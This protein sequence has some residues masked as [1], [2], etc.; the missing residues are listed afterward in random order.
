MTDQLARPTGFDF[1]DLDRTWLR[2]K[3]GV[4]WR[5]PDPDVLP[6][7]LADM[8]FPVAPPIRDALAEVMQRGDLGYPAW[9]TWSGLNPL[10]EPFGTRMS[11]FYGWQPQPEWLFNFSDI[12][13]ILQIILH[14]TTSPGDA[15]VLQ[16]PNYPPFLKTIQLMRRR[17]V[18]NPIEWSGNGWEFDPERLEQAVRTSAC[19][20]MMVVNPH[21]P[22]GRVFTRVELESLADIAVRNDMLVLADE[23]LADLAYAPRHHIPLASIGPEIAERTVTLSSI[24]KAFNVSGL[25][26]AVAHVG[27][28]HLRDELASY[29]PDFF[30]PVNVLGVEATKAAWQFGDAWL[31][32]LV[33]HLRCNRDLVA[34]TLAAHVPTIRYEPPQAAYLAWLD[35]NGLGL[36]EEPADYFLAKARVD[37]SHGADF[38][39][40]GRGFARLNFATS[41]G[42]LTEILDRITMAVAAGS[43]GSLP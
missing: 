42:I 34:A 36:D 28:A 35:C 13:Q 14:L 25:R 23:V 9:S 1:D 12:L 26:C 22:T 38:G 33:G 4:K 18:G 39:P 15:I 43:R 20:T 11:E 41:T 29:P 24:T 40:E 16:T 5:K 7:W 31:A 3:E 2:A 17:A 32:A 19:R 30:G 6:A 37:L 8:D 27:P 21:N 10:A